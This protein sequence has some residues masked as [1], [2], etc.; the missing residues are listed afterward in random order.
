MTLNRRHSF[1]VT[2]FAVMIALTFCI[3]SAQAQQTAN[4]SGSVG[5]NGTNGDV[6]NGG[7]NGTSGMSNYNA[8]GPNQAS[9]HLSIQG[10]GASTNTFT[11]TSGTAHGSA[12]ITTHLGTIGQQSDISFKLFGGQGDWSSVGLPGATTYSSAGN[13]TQATVQGADSVNGDQCS[14]SPLNGNGKASATGMSFSNA[15]G[16]GTQ[17]ASSN[18][19]TVGRSDASGDFSGGTPTIS[20]SVS[21][22]GSGGSGAL[23]QGPNGSIAGSGVVGN[24]SYQAANPSG[25]A[26]GMQA[27]KGSTTGTVNAGGN[28][29]NASATVSSTAK[30]G[31]TGH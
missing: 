15:T 26:A 13:G 31:P 23:A 27:I 16:N 22:I 12:I 10:K 30:A 8:T 2:A 25:S 9:G 6:Y 24:T 18:F 1:F 3:G 29:A 4:G 19:L 14:T 28:I 17:N 5:T 20:S 21:G 11:P 7:Y